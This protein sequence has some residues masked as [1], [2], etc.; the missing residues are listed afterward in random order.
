MTAQTTMTQD[1]DRLLERFAHACE[2]CRGRSTSPHVYFNI[3]TPIA[4]VRL[5][6]CDVNRCLVDPA[7]YFEQTLRQML[8]RLEHIPEDTLRQ[9]FV[10]P[11]SMGYYPE[12]TFLGLDVRYDRQGVP[13]IQEDHP[14]SRDPNLK[15][16]APVDFLSSGWMPQALPFYER[17][18]TMAAGRIPVEFALTWWRGCLDLA[19]Q[20]RGYEAFITDTMERPQFLHDLLRFLVE[21]RC[22]WH[23]A[24]ARHF[25][26]PLSQA[27]IGDDWINIPFITPGM[28]EDYVLPRYLDIERFHGGIRHIHSCGNQTPV[29]QHLLRIESLPELEVG[30]WSDLEQSL[31]NIPAEKRLVVFIHPNDVLCANE[32]QMRDRAARIHDLCR[33]RDYTLG[34]GGLTP[35]DGEQHYVKQIRTWMEAACTA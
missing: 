4:W 21:Q 5:W 33:G 12:Y 25:G 15:H 28:F 27:D 23:E 18:Q 8:W 2:A 35:I 34:T 1:I 20:L 13:L 6:G 26:V 16:L 29:Q 9:D 11:F 14:I 30:P 7:Y 3:E 17:L 32:R 10:L 31:L 24:C 19:I 22:R